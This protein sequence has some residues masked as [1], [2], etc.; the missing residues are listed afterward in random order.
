MTVAI[1][2]GSFLFFLLIGIPVGV[3]LGLCCLV[4][5]AATG[6]IGPA[7]LSQSLVT[8]VNSFTLLAIPFFVL[9]GELMGTGG[10]SKRLLD[11]A[12]VFFGRTT[13][14]L[15]LVAIAACMFFAALTGSGAATVA[16][17]GVIMYPEMVRRGYDKKFSIGILASA[18][19]LGVIIPPS[20]SFIMYSIFAGVSVSDMFIA[21]L[22]PGLVIGILLM[23]YCY[24]FSRKHGY[25]SKLEN[26]STKEKIRVVWEAK[27]ALICPVIILGGIYAGIFTPT[28]AAGV[29]VIYA[30]IVGLFIYK[31]MK[32]KDIWQVMSNA[33]QTCGV[34]IIIF[35][36]GATFGRILT[37]EQIPIKLANFMGSVTE[38]TVI[39]LILVN[40]LLLFVGALID[41]G[42]AIVIMTPIL[43]PIVTAVGVDPI[44]F[45]VIMS[46]NLAIGFCTPPV[47]VNL[48][49]ASGISGMS[50]DK[51][52]RGV[53]PFIFV[54]LVSLMLITYIPDLS[55]FLLSVFN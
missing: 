30:L 40:I 16:A 3:A 19:G 10:M 51:V 46:A 20:L 27:W 9:A 34:M 11:A 31:D 12:T 18:G 8:A 6:T 45:G 48:Y 32:L 29:A 13:G 37:L 43:L 4:T 28:E 25:H 53:I 41:T 17:I 7:F 2:F 49:V 47:G 36:T 52:S 35:G 26:L 54:L 14:S 21:G 55:L 15:A 5:T 44:H 1:L 33:A 38:S 22:I 23:I 50:I 24:I 42:A 39:T